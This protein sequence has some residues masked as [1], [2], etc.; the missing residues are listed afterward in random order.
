M[1][2]DFVWRKQHKP[3]E[4]ELRDN[5]G[6]GD[7]KACIS[8]TN[9]SRPFRVYIDRWTRGSSF[10]TLDT[11][12]KHIESHYAPDECED[13]GVV[14]YDVEEVICPYNEDVHGIEIEVFLCNTCYNDRQQEI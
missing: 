9:S 13:C 14:S 3:D 10:K 12:T 7:L 2:P 5:H 4:W 8:Y 1:R 6:V 11:A